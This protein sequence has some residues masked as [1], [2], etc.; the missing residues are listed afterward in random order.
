MK[1]SRPLIEST[2]FSDVLNYVDNDT[3]VLLD[4]DNTLIEPA[5]NVGTIAWLDH[6]VTKLMEKGMDK[7]AAVKKVYKLWLPLQYKITVKTVEKDIS[8]VINQLHASGI[9]TMGLTARGFG[10]AEQTDKQLKSVDIVLENNTLHDDKIVFS[11][12]EGFYKGVL[13][14]FPGEN[15]GKHLLAFFEHINNF[16]KKVLFVDD[17]DFFIEEVGVALKR[18]NIDFTGIRYGGADDSFKTVDLQKADEELVM[19]L[20]ND[21]KI[22]ELF[23]PEQQQDM[24]QK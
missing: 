16:P 23:L 8:R 7:I 9:K 15:K 11:E 21:V 1:T 10:M 4:V 12:G 17:K 20:G 6:Y 22:D 13:S 2:Q 14:I 24:V 18:L 5:T 19:Y 3:V